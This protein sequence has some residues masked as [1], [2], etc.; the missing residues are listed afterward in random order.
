MRN[1]NC[2]NAEQNLRNYLIAEQ[3]LLK[4]GTEIVECGIKS[5]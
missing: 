5:A 2:L 3:K 1:R 4:R